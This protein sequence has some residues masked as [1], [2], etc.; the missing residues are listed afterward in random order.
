MQLPN[1]LW[2]LIAASALVHGAQYMA[3]GTDLP[4]G[5]SNIEKL[6]D[7]LSFDACD[8]TPALLSFL[9]TFILTLPLFLAL[10]VAPLVFFATIVTAGSA[11]NSVG[12]QIVI[13]GTAVA[14]A[15]TIIAVLIILGSALT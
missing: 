11:A 5:A 12:G 7:L 6:I 14:L 2:G 13:A 4:E 8:G 3:C 9:F 1:W 15:G 10:I